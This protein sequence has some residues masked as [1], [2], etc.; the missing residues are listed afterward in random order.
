MPGR[1]GLRGRWGDSVEKN[2]GTRSSGGGGGGGAAL[3]RH[4]A[5]PLLEATV[6][7]MKNNRNCDFPPSPP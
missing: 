4:G 6:K 5:R 2:W 7:E 3:A 1:R